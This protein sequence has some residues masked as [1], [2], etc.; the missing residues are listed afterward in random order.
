MRKIFSLLLVVVLV[1]GCAKSIKVADPI[2]K[3]QITTQDRVIEVLKSNIGDDSKKEIIR[4]ILE[5]E[6]Q[7][8]K[9]LK[10]SFLDPGTI[11]LIITLLKH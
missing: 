9:N 5:R 7:R 8:G 2:T 11:G 1:A 4:L 3:I 10:D 6:S